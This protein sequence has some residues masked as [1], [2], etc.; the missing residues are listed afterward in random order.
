MAYQGLAA[1]KA[2]F[3]AGNGFIARIKQGIADYKLY[4]RTLGELEALTERDLQD[5]GISRY[6]IKRI[7]RDS[8]YSA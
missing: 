1:D 3:G 4:M 2:T 7:A 8:V 5:L 6:D